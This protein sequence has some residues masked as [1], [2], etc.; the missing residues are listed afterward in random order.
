M[1][2]MGNKMLAHTLSTLLFEGS[3]TNNKILSTD[4]KQLKITLNFN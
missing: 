1:E 3:K 4:T 2:K